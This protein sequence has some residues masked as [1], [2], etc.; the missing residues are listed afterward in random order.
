MTK[1]IIIKG[2]VSQKTG[3]S[4]TIFDTENSLLYKFNGTATF[5]FERIK[6]GDDYKII[7]EDMIKK[8]SIDK[9]LAEKDLTL[10]IDE[11]I[12]KGIGKERKNVY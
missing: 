1:I 4:I 6:K 10:F 9:S 3:N 11:L 8:F 2:I 7:I 12:S 5:L